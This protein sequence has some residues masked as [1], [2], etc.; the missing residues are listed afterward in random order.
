MFSI[1]AWHSC[2]CYSSIPY[3]LY[4]YRYAPSPIIPYARYRIFYR[5]LVQTCP[6]SMRLALRLYP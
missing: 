4:W 6:F 3:F 1:T 5:L 2:S